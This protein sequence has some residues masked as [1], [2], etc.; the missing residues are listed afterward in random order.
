MCSSGEMI[1]VTDLIKDKEKLTVEISCKCG[2]QYSAVIER[3][4]QKRKEVRFQGKMNPG[5]QAYPIKIVDI[6][7][8]GLKLRMTDVQNLEINDRIAVE[9]IL[10]DS[11]RSTVQKEGIVKNKGEYSVSVE[12]LSQDHYD[13]LGSYLLFHFD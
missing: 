5:K 10:D 2:H 6:S 7:R 3:R 11:K 9:F 4:K 8:G 13:S 1:D 12:F